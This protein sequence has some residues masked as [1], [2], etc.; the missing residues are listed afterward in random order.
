MTTILLFHHAHGRTAGFLAFADALRGAGHEVVTP[1]L[2]EGQV[3]ADLSEGVAFAQSIGFGEIIRHGRAAAEA[4]PAG[5]V[6]AGFSLGA[7]P[8]Q[9]VAQTRAGARGVLLF[10]GGEPAA[11]FSVGWPPGLP[12]E[13]HTAEADPWMDMDRTRQLIDAATVVAATRLFIYPGSGHLFADPG[14]GDY[15][16]GSAGLLLG[17]TLDFLARIGD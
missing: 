12:L 10:H 11:E 4:L 2:Y 16:T 13:I 5:I 17:R 15:D 7:L 8:A 1:D 6:Y 14:S 9:A 3:F